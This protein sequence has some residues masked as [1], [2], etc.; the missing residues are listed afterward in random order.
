MFISPTVFATQSSYRVKLSGPV[1]G[2]SS[3]AAAEHPMAT[4]QLRW[5]KVLLHWQGCLSLGPQGMRDKLQ[6]VRLGFRNGVLA[7]EGG[8]QIR[9][10]KLRVCGHIFTKL[11]VSTW[12]ILI[13]RKTSPLYWLKQ[14]IVSSPVFF[15]KSHVPTEKNTKDRTWTVS[16]TVKQI[17]QKLSGLVETPFTFSAWTWLC[18]FMGRHL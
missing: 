16:I 2:A 4:L 12:I 15:L 13:N 17:T 6:G 14:H 5:D 9:G 8:R 7:L 11:P 1:S 3:P 18:G 10:P